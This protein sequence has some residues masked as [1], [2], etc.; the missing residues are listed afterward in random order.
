MYNQKIYIPSISPCLIRNLKII[1]KDNDFIGKDD[2][3]GCFDFSMEK[4]ESNYFSKPRWIYIYG[5]YCDNP[6]DK[7]AY[8]YMNSYPEM[9][10]RFK[11]QFLMS[12]DYMNIDNSE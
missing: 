5:A 11:G 3:I 6:Y 10:S 1:C 8:E 7:E 12:I 4:I 9:A 2:L